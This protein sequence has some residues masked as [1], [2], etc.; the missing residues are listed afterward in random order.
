MDQDRLTWH[1]SIPITRTRSGAQHHL[2]HISWDD[3]CA[4]CQH[5]NTLMCCWPSKDITDKFWNDCKRYRG[6]NDLSTGRRPAS[7]GPGRANG[8]NRQAGK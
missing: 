5:Y 4:L 2:M 3:L 7:N 8:G 6:K 1:L